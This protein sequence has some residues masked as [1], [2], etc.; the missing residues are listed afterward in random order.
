MCR[1]VVLS[2]PWGLGRNVPS[3][4]LPLVLVSTHSHSRLCRRC[5][6]VL[7]VARIARAGFPTRYTH[8]Q[9]VERYTSLLPP[10]D[11][12]ELARSGDAL[13]ACHSLIGT[14]NLTAEQYQVRCMPTWVSC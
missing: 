6:G 10:R 11:Q 2:H 14:F 5:C 8:A 12:E 13:A 1:T 3:L 7:E 4:A 9:F